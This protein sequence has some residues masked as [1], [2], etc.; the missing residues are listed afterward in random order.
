VLTVWW[1]TVSTV[2]TNVNRTSY[3]TLCKPEWCLYLNLTNLKKKMQVLWNMALYRLVDSSYFRGVFFLSLHKVVL[4]H[5][6]SN[7]ATWDTV[8]WFSYLDL[9]CSCS[10]VNKIRMIYS[11]LIV[12]PLAVHMPQMCICHTCLRR[13]LSLCYVGPSMWNTVYHTNACR[14]KSR[15]VKKKGKKKKVAT[16]HNRDSDLSMTNACVAI[17]SITNACVAILLRWRPSWSHNCA[18]SKNI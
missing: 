15:F 13:Q 10:E 14:K 1:S 11:L 5:L 4:K 8:N 7:V 3:H 16:L 17:L 6:S 2:W 9:Q 12:S 18:V